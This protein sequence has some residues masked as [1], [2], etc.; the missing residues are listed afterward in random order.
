MPRATPRNPFR[1]LPEDVL[2]RQITLRPGGPRRGERERRDRKVSARRCAVEIEI[3]MRPRGYSNSMR[4][5]LFCISGP[6]QLPHRGPKLYTSPFPFSRCRLSRFPSLPPRRPPFPI[7]LAAFLICQ[8]R[9]LRYRIVR[10]T[11]RNNRESTAF[12]SIDRASPG[13]GLKLGREVTPPLMLT[14]A[15]SI[16][17]S[18]LETLIREKELWKISFA[19]LRKRRIKPCGSLYYFS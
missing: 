4:Q 19:V 1:L 12:K 5:P 8:V 18:I 17:I 16:T 3:Q 15:H 13:F 9:V 11:I 14:L 2:G 6:T 7:P 10:A